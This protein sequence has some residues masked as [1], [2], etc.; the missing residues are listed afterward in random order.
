MLLGEFAVKTVDTIN[1][2]LVHN[3]L[4][5]DVFYLEVLY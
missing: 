2:A 5:S 1:K 3:L 4:V